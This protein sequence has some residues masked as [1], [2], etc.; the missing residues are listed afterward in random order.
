MHC[1]NLVKRFKDHF[2][3]LVERLKELQELVPAL[4]IHGHNEDCQFRHNLAYQRGAGRTHG[5]NLGG[6]WGTSNN[7]GGMTKEMNKGHRHDILNDFNG[8]WNW[9]KMQEL[10]VYTSRVISISCLDRPVV[11]ALYRGL[12]K[13]REFTE[14]SRHALV[15]LNDLFGDKN[16]EEWRKQGTAPQ[17]VNGEWTSVYRMP[18]AKG[19]SHQLL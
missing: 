14:K 4:H 13:A 2:P 9:C 1:I 10:G 17:Q 16:V 11:N 7:E 19:T 8:Y 3:D 18:K 5:E 15:A 12:V 6:T